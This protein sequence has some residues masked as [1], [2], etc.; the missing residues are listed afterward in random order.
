MPLGP[1]H[2][3]LI[4]RFE[5]LGE[6]VN[7]DSDLVRRGARCHAEL[8]AGIGDAM[9]YVRVAEGRVVQLERQA[10]LPR[11]WQFTIRAPAE[12]W[13]KFWMPVPEPGWHDLSALTKRG[14]AGIEGDI[15]PFMTHLQFFKDMFAA[16][17]QLSQ[18]RR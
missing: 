6:L 13:R 9:F 3:D 1:D 11:P 18:A 2:A 5:R 8:E 17:R 7:G 10:K 4:A 15:T 14:V 16:P 12:A